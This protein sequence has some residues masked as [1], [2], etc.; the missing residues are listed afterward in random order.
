MKV[1]KAG[2]LIYVVKIQNN[3]YHPWGIKV[4]KGKRGI[5]ECW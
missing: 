1:P 5:L 4:G 3:S 2:K